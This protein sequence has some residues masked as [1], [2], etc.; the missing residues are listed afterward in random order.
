MLTFDHMH[1]YVHGNVCIHITVLLYIYKRGI[2]IYIYILI[3]IYDIYFIIYRLYKNVKC[4]L[5]I[6]PHTM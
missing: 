2:Y 4:I 6:H 3:Y 5:Y 1:A